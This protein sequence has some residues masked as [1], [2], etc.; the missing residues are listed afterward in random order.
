MGGKDKRIS[1]VT[2][3]FITLSILSFI[4]PS[5]SPRIKRGI[6]N[7]E[8][9]TQAPDTTTGIQSSWTLSGRDE[10]RTVPSRSAPGMNDASRRSRD[11][12][13]R[14]HVGE[15]EPIGSVMKYNKK[16]YLPLVFS[17]CSQQ[18]TWG[19]PDLRAYAN[20]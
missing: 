10:R 9:G 12:K 13:Y 19:K 4:L 14:L 15:G 6:L 18:L 1:L 20:P 16:E 17:L 3:Q 2:N 5:C 7:P 8:G 11:E